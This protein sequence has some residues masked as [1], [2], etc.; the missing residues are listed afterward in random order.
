MLVIGSREFPIRGV[1]S[2]VGGI[3]FYIQN[4]LKHMKK[5]GFG[6]S[7]YVFS[8]FVPGKG[9]IEHLSNRIKII[10]TPFVRFRL[11]RL[12]VSDFF[13]FIYSLFMIRRWKINI[14]HVHETIAGFFFGII[15]KIYKIPLVSQIH[16]F[17]SYQPEWP[18]IGRILLKKTEEITIRFADTVILL[19]T[20]ARNEVITRYGCPPEKIEVIFSA[21]DFERFAS[22]KTAQNS[23]VKDNELLITFVGRLTESKGLHYLIDA[24]KHLKTSNSELVPFKVI[25]AGDGPLKK[26]LED[27]IHKSGLTDQISLPGHITK[28]ESLLAS[29]DIFILPSLYEGFPLALLEAMASGCAIIG[30]NAGGIPDIITNSNTG[31]IVNRGDSRALAERIKLLLIDKELRLKLGM[32]GREHVRKKFRWVNTARSI[33]QIYKRICL[34]KMNQ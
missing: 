9:L 3:D 23:S 10:H 6:Y 21:V 33:Y 1:H 19:C 20:E 12:I 14:I 7:L 18:K 13:A 29:T 30:S 16:T 17:G 11:L 28:I 27:F 34:S 15:S 26:E 24:I 25:I 8:R 22:I 31:I 5:L 32:S 2:D 4:L